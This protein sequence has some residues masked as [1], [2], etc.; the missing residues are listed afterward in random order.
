MP[1]FLSGDADMHSSVLVATNVSKIYVDLNS[2]AMKFAVLTYKT[3]RA[4]PRAYTDVHLMEC[5]MREIVLRIAAPKLSIAHT[6]GSENMD[7]T[8]CLG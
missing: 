3:E 1:P 8:F 2:Y 5:M 4:P 7:N 6:T